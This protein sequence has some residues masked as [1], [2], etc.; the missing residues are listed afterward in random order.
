MKRGAQY[1]RVVIVLALMCWVLPA[2][3]V[4]APITPDTGGDIWIVEVQTGSKTSAGEE[5]IQIFNASAAPIDVSQWRLE[6]FSAGVANFDGNPTRAVILHGVLES[7][8]RYMIASTGYMAGLTYDS[9]S[10]GLA[11]AGGHLRLVSPGENSIV[12]THDLVGW[13]T[14][15]HPEGSH[16][17]PAPT[18]GQSIRRITDTDGYFLDSDDNSVDFQVNPAP[19]P[20]ADNL[21]TVALDTTADAPTDQGDSTSTGT[22]QNDTSTDITPPVT[23]TPPSTTQ[24]DDS[25]AP[26]LPFLPVEIDELLPNPAAPKT[27]ANDEFVEL[28]NANDTAVDLSLYKLQ[29]GLTFSHSTLLTG[30]TIQPHS[31]LSIFSGNTSLSLSNTG[32]NARLLDPEGTVMSEIPPYEEA[33][34]GQAWILYDNI[35]QW[36]TTPTPNAVNVLST[37]VADQPKPAVA[38]TTVTKTATKKAAASTKKAA[39]PAKKATTAK[40]TTVKAASAKKTTTSAKKT[41]S[42]SGGSTARAAETPSSLHPF[43]LAGVGTLAVGYGAYEYREDILNKIR[44]RRANRTSGRVGR[45][46]PEGR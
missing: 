12:I 22:S 18:A 31:Y 44:R 16:T 20:A 25:P 24:G 3:A 14:A 2:R 19:N 9:F 23:P 8:K 42:S 34:E 35:W 7:G 27:D 39:T 38:A 11:A 5:F 40:K 15:L 37:P 21:S 41:T 1:V 43:V 26:V 46:M 17:A 30:Y 6:Y 13:G 10:A 4:D 29:S 36:S 45:P 28:Y 33:A 32:G